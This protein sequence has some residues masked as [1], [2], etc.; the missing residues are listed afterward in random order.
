MKNY[1]QQVAT[2]YRSVANPFWYYERL[3]DELLKIR[4]LE[5]VP[6]CELEA[7]DASGKRIISLRHDV[8]AD[9]VTA[10]RAAR[11]LARRGISG[12]F[13]LLHTAPYY[14]DLFRGIFVRNAQLAEWIKEF[15]VAGCEIGLHIDPFYFYGQGVDGAQAVRVELDW[16]RQQGARID[17]VCAHN[18]APLYGAESFEIFEGCSARRRVKLLDVDTW[19]PLQTLR[20]SQLELN[21]E[22]N[23]PLPRAPLNQ[24]DLKNFI[25][26][27]LDDAV[28]NRRWMRTYLSSHPIFDRDYDYSIW[29][30][31]RDRWVIGGHRAQSSRFLWD[32]TSQQVL[33]WF[34]DPSNI[35]KKAVMTIHPAYLQSEDDLP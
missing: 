5:I 27:P 15:V 10:L 17:G 23:F 34:E 31:G 11:H 22:A 19:V 29:L 16:L 33:H 32:L 18:S 8:D 3:V 12:S 28:Q 30:L 26:M 24:R 7:A 1:A 9:P 13:F 14:G 25:E 2:C 20:L 21:Y 4:D 35:G 6:L